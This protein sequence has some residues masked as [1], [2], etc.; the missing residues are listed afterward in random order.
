MV[1]AGTSELWRAFHLHRASASAG[2][3]ESHSLL[4]FYAAEC[5]LKAVWLRRNQKLSSEQ[6]P[7]ALAK[8]GHDLSLWLKELRV[9]AT[10]RPAP[11][12]RVH[13]DNH[14]LSIAEVHEAWR[15]GVRMRSEDESRL[16]SWLT[17][18][19]AWVQEAMYR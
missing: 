5:G 3:S 10:V 14:A 6:F 11:V 18:V 13:R 16:R 12:V 15:Y 19:C 7:E 4:L 8:H 2:E 1:K 9:G 17:R